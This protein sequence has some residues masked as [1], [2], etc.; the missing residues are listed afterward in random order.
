MNLRR[1]CIASVLLGMLSLGCSQQVPSTVTKLPAKAPG[2]YNEQIVIGGHTRTYILRV[3]HPYDALKPLPLVVGLHGLSGTAANFE[4]SSGLASLSESKG[5]ILVSPDGLGSDGF[6]G[7]NAGFFNLTGTDVDDVAFVDRLI[8]KIKTEV[9]VDSNRIYV[10]G[11]SN[12]AFMAHLLAAKMPTKFA[13]VACVAGTIGIPDG[14]G[15]VKEIPAPAAPISVLLIHGV[16]DS[17]VQFDSHSQAL[18]HGVGAMDSAKFW[19]K[20]DACLP[21]PTEIRS[22]NGNVITHHFA[23]GK[24]GTEVELVEILNGG[25]D[26]PG[27]LTRFGIENKTG[28]RAAELAWNFFES[29][30]KK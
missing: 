8:E 28:V 11:H 15:A 1:F 25:H 30:P 26:W 4:S 20:C 12:G 29:H 21:Q 19:A 27:G 7:W 2:Q 23:G 18:L 16:M 6:H 3:P 10:A 13:A 9:G 24:N 17:M 5:F 14:D 22:V